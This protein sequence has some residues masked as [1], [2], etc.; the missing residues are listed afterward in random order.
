M[1]RLLGLTA[2]LGPMLFLAGV[3]APAAAHAPHLRYAPAGGV[4]IHFD[5][6][7]AAVAIGD[8]FTLPSV[9]ANTGTAPTDRFVAHLDVVSLTSDVY[10]DPEDWS[11]IRSRD[12]APIPPGGRTPVDWDLQAVNAG[13]FDVYLV[14]L[15]NGPASAGAGPL[16]VS[17]PVH[18]TVAAR[19]T[20]SAGGALPVAV[21]VPL[22]LGLVAATLRYR[23][24]RT[25]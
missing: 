7:E 5:Q 17:P 1:R 12:L 11:G 3:A 23:R 6:G 21:A 13:S 2:V 10:V 4:E 16:A 19:R 24:R 15:P 18:V 14:L 22:V 9:I 20:L 25:D 8:R